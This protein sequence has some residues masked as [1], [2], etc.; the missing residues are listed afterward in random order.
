MPLFFCPSPQDLLA[1]H[2]SST[3]SSL[4]QFLAGLQQRQRVKACKSW[5]HFPPHLH[6]FFF[7]LIKCTINYCR[8]IYYFF[9]FFKNT[10][11][12]VCGKVLIN[13]KLTGMQH[14]S[15]F[16]FAQKARFCKIIGHM[17][18]GFSDPG[19]YEN[20]KC[21]V[22]FSCSYCAVSTSYPK[23]EIFFLLGSW[24][25]TCIPHMFCSLLL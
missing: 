15:F 10:A 2:H 8:N 3:A 11:V 17:Q 4:V 16:C 7:F 24:Q 14:L 1:A 25:D 19:Q 12:A 13:A 20:S 23:C 5:I 6:F 22:N 21:T 18:V 9:F